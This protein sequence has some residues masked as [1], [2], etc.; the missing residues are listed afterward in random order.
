MTRQY[1][2]AMAGC[3]D[4]PGSVT[5]PD[6]SA[7]RVELLEEWHRLYGRPPPPRLSTRLLRLGVAYERQARVNG[8]LK[9]K[10]RKRLHAHAQ[11]NGRAT[12]PKKVVTERV[13]ATTGT[14]LV[15]EWHGRTHV[16]DVLDRGILY[17]GRTYRS[18]SEVAR[19]ITGARWSGPRF[20]GL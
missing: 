12:E 9:T 1:R 5:T 2:S 16:V 11:S 10:T 7:T 6:R 15:R 8:G 4:A 19:A 18:L 20:F 14:R 17:E 3:G 13:D